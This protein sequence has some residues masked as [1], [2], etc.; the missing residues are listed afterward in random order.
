MTRRKQFFAD[1]RRS[2]YE[3]FL[4]AG[5]FA[6]AATVC[7]LLYLL[8]SRVLFLVLYGLCLPVVSRPLFFMLDAR[9]WRW[10]WVPCIRP[11]THTISG[12]VFRGLRSRLLSFFR[13]PLSLLRLSGR[14]SVVRKA[15]GF[16]AGTIIGRVVLWLGILI[17]L[18][19]CWG[20]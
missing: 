11:A 19:G 9:Y 16:L 8:T 3:A 7:A 2:L 6:F 14:F 1:V 18:R 15:L 20:L 10:G 5:L 17:L 13:R 4:L 12:S